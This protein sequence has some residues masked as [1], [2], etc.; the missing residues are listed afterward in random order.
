MANTRGENSPMVS[1]RYG[2]L[3]VLAVLA[4]GPR[5][6]EMKL[7]MVA[8]N[9]AT[10]SQY[11]NTHSLMVKPLKNMGNVLAGYWLN[12]MKMGGT[13]LYGSDTKRDQTG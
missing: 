11:S 10:P 8:R 6:Y 1:M 9:D 7:P 4:P 3:A 13:G 5:V 2:V 12:G